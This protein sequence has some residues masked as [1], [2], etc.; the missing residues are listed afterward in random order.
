MRPA[1]SRMLPAL[2]PLAKIAAVLPA[3]VALVFVRDLRTPLV[4]LALAAVVLLVGAPWTRTLLLAL[5]VAVPVMVLAVGLGLSLWAD[6]SRLPPSAEVLRFGGVVLYAAALEVGAATALRLAAI[7]ALALIGGL[8]TTGE[9]LVRALVRQLH[10]PYRIGYAALAAFRFAPRFARELELI[11]QAHRVRGAG[12]RGPYGAPWNA[13][14]R[15]AGYAVPLLAGGIRHAERVA[16][17]MDARAFGA[18]PTRTERHVVPWR[19]RDTA[20]VVAGWV[21]TLALFVAL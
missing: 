5:F 14:A 19:V 8:T 15:G 1:S 9:D 10:V 12:G 21:L 2:N 17:A 11:R 20:F 4:F 13:A 18:H 16:L 6:A 3:M 7:L